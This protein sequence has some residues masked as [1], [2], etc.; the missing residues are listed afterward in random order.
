M[1]RLYAVTVAPGGAALL[2]LHVCAAVGPLRASAAAAERRA[3][4]I[5]VVEAGRPVRRRAAAGAGARVNKG[6]APPA[7]RVPEPVAQM[8]RR[9][10]A[11]VGWGRNLRGVRA[12]HESC[13]TKLAA[14]TH[15]ATNHAAP[16]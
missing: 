5:V 6:S 11:R 12:H 9:R 16:T 8:E 1:V 7:T 2:H 4:V 3:L 14:T 13:P 15:C 10:G